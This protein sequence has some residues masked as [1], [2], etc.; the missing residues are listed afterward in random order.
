M[1][2]E[3]IDP[4]IRSA[5]KAREFSQGEIQYREYLTSSQ[6]HQ[7]RNQALKEAGYRCHVCDVKRN[8]QVHHVS[9]ERLGA[10]LPEDLVVV[11]RGC[12]LG[13]HYNETQDG[14]GVY[15][16]VL[17]QVIQDFPDAEFSDVIEETKT[18]CAKAKIRINPD[19]FNAAVARVN[20]RI[21][22]TPPAH[23]RELFSQSGHDE[24]LTRAEACGILAK[25]G[26]GPLMKHM[27]EEKPLSE[28]GQAAVRAYGLY[29]QAIREQIKRC[30]EAE[31]ATVEA[32]RAARTEPN[33]E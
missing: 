17:S 29:M 21:K 20:E 14:I 24:P 25:L 32:E 15:T 23:K 27:P 6:W 33:R 28:D 1:R 4:A 30:E 7:R 31:R 11:C 3:Y 22:F 13:H 19:R 12:H 10:E 2:P 8:L 5:P 9:Y 16:R 26:A 18:Q